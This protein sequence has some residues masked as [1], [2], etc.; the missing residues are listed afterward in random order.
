[1]KKFAK[2]LSVIVLTLSVVT[3]VACGSVSQKYADKVN[4]AAKE[5]KYVTYSEVQ[6]ALGDPGL[7]A[8]GSVF[9]SGVTGVCT[10]YK[11]AKTYDA[12]KAKVDAGKSG[13][14]IAITF[15]DGAA[16]AA[17][18]GVWTAEEK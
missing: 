12:A 17:T 1:M 14:Y 18:Y 10:W 9:G 7:N 4:S 11:G 2:L 16:T 13:P 8:S 15:V 5:K 3:L 6:K